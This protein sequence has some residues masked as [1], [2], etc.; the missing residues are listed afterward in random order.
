M[1]VEGRIGDITFQ[2]PVEDA[3]VAQGPRLRCLSR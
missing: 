1:V 2:V 3:G